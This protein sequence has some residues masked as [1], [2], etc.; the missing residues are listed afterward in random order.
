M[1]PAAAGAGQT[2]HRPPGPGGDA[3]RLCAQGPGRPR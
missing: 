3:R 1:I 2:A